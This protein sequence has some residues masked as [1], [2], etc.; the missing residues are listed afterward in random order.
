MLNNVYN[1]GALSKIVPSPT[2]QLQ[3][4]KVAVAG[5]ANIWILSS[6]NDEVLVVFDG[7]WE[8]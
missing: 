1:G 8:G 6:E 3:S 2:G 5:S 4:D 7:G